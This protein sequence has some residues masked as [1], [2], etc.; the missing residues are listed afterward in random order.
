[1]TD[2]YILEAVRTAIG[3]R[4][5]ALSS[6]RPDD[7]AGATL[8]GLV[9]RAGVEDAEIEDVIMGCV[10]QIDEQGFNIGR[11]AALA[12]GFPVSV[13]GTTVNRMCASSLQSTNFAAQAVMSGAMDMVI[14]AGVESMS[15]VAMGSDGGSIS[16]SIGKRFDIIP[17]GLSAE[18]ICDRWSLSRESLDQLSFDS[19]QRALKASAEGHYAREILPIDVTVDGETTSFATDQGPRANTTIEKLHSLKPAFRED[20]RITAASSSQ[21]S[22]G[23]SAIL[24]GSGAKADELGL[25]KRARFRSMAVAGVD[26]TIM[27][28]GVI[29]A[30]EKALKKAGMNIG[31]VD[32]FEVN[33]AFASVVLAWSADTGGDLAKTNVNGGAMALGHPLGCSGARLVTTL[34]HEME[35]QDKNVG[36]A[37]LCIGFGMAVATVIERV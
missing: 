31:D 35:R 2:A 37:T 15:R 11:M 23:A 33:E 29:P 7:L 10:T 13:P 25:K 32:L 6:I 30:T 21:I 17:Q 24:V 1:M 5:G 8:R 18:L 34:L 27:L 19:H 36:L 28:T 22:D 4:G 12:A 26:P 14:G 3:K 16:D 9:D 20:G